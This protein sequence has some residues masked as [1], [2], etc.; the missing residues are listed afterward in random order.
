M[1]AVPPLFGKTGV[2]FGPK[3]TGQPLSGRLYAGKTRED[4]NIN[5]RA[6]MGLVTR[7]G[8]IYLLGAVNPGIVIIKGFA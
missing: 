4:R 8:Q 7:R 5:V 6:M 1:V 2:P 3:I